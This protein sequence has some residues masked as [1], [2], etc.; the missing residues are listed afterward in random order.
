M[1]LQNFYC[2]DKKLFIARISI[3]VVFDIYSKNKICHYRP[4]NIC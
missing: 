2:L 1:S 3:A 4:T